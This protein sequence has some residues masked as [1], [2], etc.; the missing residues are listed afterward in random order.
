MAEDK[1][2]ID[3]AALV[4]DRLPALLLYA[5]QW[6]HDSPED[7]VQEAFISLMN[8]PQQP[9]NVTHW[10]FTV[11]RNH[12]NKILRTR[13]RQREREQR[14]SS[15]KEAWFA[16]EVDLAD[17]NDEINRLVAELKLLPPKYRKIIVAKIWGKLTFAE[18]AEIHG[19]SSSSVH[20]DYHAGLKILKDNLT[21]LIDEVKNDSKTK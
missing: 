13:K 10:L 17:Q 4:K 21:K 14:F 9:Q 18:I 6:P 5:R 7:V 11:V 2:N 8:Q 3:F 15:Q 20:R 1:A 12:S 16:Q 19:T